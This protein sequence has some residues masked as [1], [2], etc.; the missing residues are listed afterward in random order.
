MMIY[1]IMISMINVTA[2]IIEK[3]GTILIARRKIGSH[4]GGK[5]EFPGGKI[6]VGE[7]P[8]QCLKRELSE[9]FGVETAVKDF[10]EESIFDYGEKVICLRG[11]RVDYLSGDFVL[12]AHE[13]IL[14]VSPTELKLYEFCPADLPIVEKLLCV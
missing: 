11:Y 7:T 6:E 10:V 14:W 12:N 3:D 4:M 9:E 1:C 8:E 2:G 5:W 13:E